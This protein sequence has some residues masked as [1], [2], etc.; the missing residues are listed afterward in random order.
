MTLSWLR[1]W[2]GLPDDFF[3]IIHDTA[4][5]SSLHAILAARE[6][7]APETRLTGQHPRLILY[8]AEH[9]HSSIER[10]ALALGI[11]RENVRLVPADADFRMRKDALATLIEQDIA[12]GHKPF[13]V[14]A[15][16]GTT[17]STSVDPLL[18]IAEIA[19]DLSSFGDEQALVTMTRLATSSTLGSI[20]V[21]DMAGSKAQV[22]PEGATFLSARTS[23]RA[24]HR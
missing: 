16:L 19:D 13:C 4:S 24:A 14:V 3:G 11:G 9:A 12:S 20:P 21:F 17:S 18:A 23:A 1:Q 5:T 2:L 22:W 8:T 7:A 6:A 15:T 10:G